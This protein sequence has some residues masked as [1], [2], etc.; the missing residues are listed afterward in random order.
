MA[1]IL[2]V[3]NIQNSLG[4]DLLINGYPRQ[5]GQVLE[6]L[7]GP[8]DGR[9]VGGYTWPDVTAVLPLTAAY[10]DVTGSVITYTPPSGAANVFYKFVWQIDCTGYSGISHYRFYI[11][12]EE[13]I[14][15]YRSIAP[16]E[17]VSN[18]HHNANEVFEWAIQCN[19]GSEDASKGQFTSWTSPKT[20]KLYAREYDNSSYQQVLHQNVWRDGGGAVAPYILA[21]P[22]LTIVAIA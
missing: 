1:S 20:L 8:C 15:A 10:T 14:G 22:Q 18:A 19:A 17:Y 9:T 5:P 2:K 11:D 16:G 3:D 4:Q 6:Y 12:S 21:I 13:V 7:S